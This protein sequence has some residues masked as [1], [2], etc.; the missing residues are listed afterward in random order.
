MHVLRFACL[1]SV[2]AVFVTFYMMPKTT[3]TFEDFTRFAK[4]SSGAVALICLM[5]T[6]WTGA[7]FSSRQIETWRIH[8]IKVRPISSLQT[9][10]GQIGGVFLCYLISF[11]AG[12]LTVVGFS[13]YSIQQLPENERQLVRQNFINTRQEITPAKPNFL[14]RAKEMAEQRIKATGLPE[15]YSFQNLQNE[16]ADQLAVRSG[17][18]LPGGVISFS[19]SGIDASQ[20]L[21]LEFEATITDSAEKGFENPAVG[22]FYFRH[23]ESGNLYPQLVRFKSEKSTRIQINPAFIGKSGELYIE[24]ENR[25][26]NRRLIYFSP[27]RRPNVVVTRDNF[28]TNLFVAATVAITAIYF[29]S[30]LGIT[31]GLLFS[32]PV[33]LF[34]CFVYL[35]LA[36]FSD[37]QLMKGVLGK[38]LNNILVS[39]FYSDALIFISEGKFV[40]GSFVLKSSAVIFGFSAIL[41][42]SAFTLFKHRELALVFRKN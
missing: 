29:F 18:L 10:L 23:N 1:L 34:F 27:Q 16:Y 6:L 19:Y 2:V 28:T 14:I 41:I 17:E 32:A 3:Q 31:I 38:Q 5:G 33:A 12:I 21:F 24:F 39:P 22:A 35:F 9:V 15:G 13:Y 26:E 36:L 40:S 7:I 8:L 37:L 4:Y 42:V 30:T 11:I 25:D 20:L